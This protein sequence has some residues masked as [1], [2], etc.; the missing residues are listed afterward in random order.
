MCK[1][2]LPERDIISE[3]LAA[4]TDI[5]AKADDGILTDDASPS[6]KRARG[7]GSLFSLPIRAEKIF[8]AVIVLLLLARVLWVMIPLT[9]HFATLAK[10]ED[11]I[12]IPVVE[13]P[14]DT[15][16]IVEA[17][18]EYTAHPDS[19]W[20]DDGSPQGKIIVAYPLGHGKGQIAMRVSH[21]MGLTWSDRTTGLPARRSAIDNHTAVSNGWYAWVGTFDELLSYANDD[22]SDD[23]K[24]EYL[25][26]LGRTY[27]PGKPY[28]VAHDNGYSGVV[29]VNGV[30]NVVG[31][32]CFDNTGDDRYI[33][34]RTFSLA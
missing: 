19:V 26:E 31:Y 34:S 30:F 5:A 15:A 4:C 11:F 7:R 6:E 8:L 14:A 12:D 22:P 23:S 17:Q 1:S 2:E 18:G 32:G 28:D 3:E 27:Y 20:V 16:V 24:G 9:V 29:C 33:I 13:L 21:D 10:P 25:I